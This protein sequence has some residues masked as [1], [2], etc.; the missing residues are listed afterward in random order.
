MGLGSNPLMLLTK[1]ETIS[2][3]LNWHLGH[4]SWGQHREPSRQSPRFQVGAG[5]PNQALSPKLFPE[6]WESDLAF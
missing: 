3:S 2:K 5:I 6:T 1:C 4:L